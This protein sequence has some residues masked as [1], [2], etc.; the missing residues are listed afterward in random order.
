VAASF[1]R[2]V[3][4]PRV[5]IRPSEPAE[6]WD[7]LTVLKDDPRARFAE[8]DTMTLGIFKHLSLVSGSLANQVPDAFLAAIAL[9]HD[10]T[11]LTV[12]RDFLRYQALKVELLSSTS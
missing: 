4:N 11:F 5:F 7:F 10:A 8:A 12:D 9:R 2:L 1:L 6:A 3:T